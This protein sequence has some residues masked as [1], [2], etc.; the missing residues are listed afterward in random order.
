MQYPAMANRDAG[1][2]FFFT[3]QRESQRRLLLVE[4]RRTGPRHPQRGTPSVLK[5]LA[6][7][8]SGTSSRAYRRSLDGPPG[9]YTIAWFAGISGPPE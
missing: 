7:Q 9:P 5:G 3:G 4:L 8:P 6:E 1:V 2:G